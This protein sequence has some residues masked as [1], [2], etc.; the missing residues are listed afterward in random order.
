[1]TTTLLRQV[2]EGPKLGTGKKRKAPSPDDGSL[3]EEV[4][5]KAKRVRTGCRTCRAR[6]LKC[7]EEHPIC[8]Q[9]QKSNKDCSWEFVLKWHNNKDKSLIIGQ[10]PVLSIDGLDSMSQSTKDRLHTVADYP[11]VTFQDMSREIA[12][13][14]VDGDKAY[15]P[16]STP[17][18]DN[19]QST[20]QQHASHITQKPSN[21]GHPTPQ[22]HLPSYAVSNTT[23][24]YTPES[25]HGSHSHN[26]SD[27]SYLTAPTSYGVYATPV[28][29]PGNSVME[30]KTPKE[31]LLMQVFVE[32]VG[33]WMD[34]MNPVKHFSQLLPHEAMYEPMLY[35][36]LLACGAK[37]LSLVNPQYKEEESLPYYETATSL[38]LRALQNQD[39]DTVRCATTA[40]CLNVY[41]IMTE[42]A[43]QR[44][45][46]IAGA[47]AL[48]K[49][50]H[51]NAKSTGIGAACFWLNVGMEILSCLHFNW[52]VAWDPDTWGIDMNMQPEME[53][54]KEEFWCHRMLYII[55]KISNF[56]ATIPRDP[57]LSPHYAQ[58]RHQERV[59]EWRY[60]Q[61]LCDIWFLNRPRTMANMLRVAPG[62]PNNSCFPE[63][64]YT[65]RA[66]PVAALFY[67]TAMCL[68]AQ[69]NPNL[70]KENPTM[71]SQMMQHAHEICSIVVHSKDRGIASVAI[72]SLAIAADCLTVRREQEE[73]LLRFDSIKEQTGWRIGFINEELKLKWGWE[74]EDQ[75]LMPP[76][77]T[78]V[79]QAQ[80]YRPPQP[81][82]QQAR[83]PAPPSGILNPLLRTAD[84]SLPDHPYPKHYQ[85]PR[86]HSD[87]SHEY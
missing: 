83:P 30:I 81:A 35:H 73:V 60:L 53:L 6:H 12:D 65:G 79:S 24:Q 5:A 34:S 61:G 62:P 18:H 57:E 8:G 45:N 77:H 59:A 80:A 27:Y 29:T 9:C 31:A 23:G 26:G 32:E 68:L 78:M 39:R 67:H 25:R 21:Y 86:Q 69:I 66:A 22:A 38:L 55:A 11:A 63:T 15:P 13:Y 58:A 20:S 1:M 71:N 72:R 17:P 42:R 87:Y 49:E 44:M 37:H 47:R 16:L 48:V 36:A 4:E 76:F 84:F 75:Q 56:R 28:Q 52:Q 43:M 14:Y 50:C 46:H 85:P 51:W 2:R 19:V 82:P 40:V 33:L 54:G 3:A 41:E 64:W 10:I 70:S 7:G 74:E